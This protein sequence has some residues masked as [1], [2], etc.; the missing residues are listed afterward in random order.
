MAAASI[1]LSAAL[2][3]LGQTP[4]GE[5]TGT[6][7]PDPLAAKQAMIRDGI[8]RLEDRMLRLSK[9]LAD[10]DP[11]SATRLEQ[12]LRRARELLIIRKT[13][14]IIGL[15]EQDRLTDA[16][17]KQ[18]QAIE[19][20]HTILQL[21]LRELGDLKKREEEIRRLEELRDELAAIIKEQQ[22]ERADSRQA[23][24]LE[25]Q[26]AAINR[27][28]A[29]LK[30][31]IAREQDELAKTTRAEAASSTDDGPGLA[32]S[33]QA[34]RTDT[35]AFAERLGK[36]GEMSKAG[37]A[38]KPEPNEA[39]P[40]ASDLQQA[41]EAINQAASEM[42][43]AEQN[44][45]GSKLG[46]AR[47]DQEGAIEDLRRALQRLEKRHSAA[48][49]KLDY[50]KQAA[51]Q[52]G[53]EAKTGKLAERMAGGQGTG[54]QGASQAAQQQSQPAPGTQNVQQAQKRM[55]Q[56]AD[57]LDCKDP[58]EAGDQQDKALDEL[59]QAQRQLED[60]LR[61]LQREQQQETLAALEGRFRAMLAKQLEIN[62]TTV[63]L[64]QTRQDHWRRADELKLSEL[65]KEQHGLGDE[66][67]K[68]VRVL[69]QDATTVVFPRIVD[70]IRQEMYDV[71][72]R[73]ADKKVATVTQTM[74]AEIAAT[75][76]DLIDALKQ[77]R[78]G[79]GGGQGGAGC[80]GKMALLPGSAEL[81]LLR[82]CQ[83]RVKNQTET[84]D[85]QRRQQP[86]PRADLTARMK[87]LSQRQN[88]LARMAKQIHE[89]AA[90]CSK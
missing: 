51:A 84:L 14:E 18:K 63:A 9:A 75:L 65:S 3:G 28:I 83:V 45:S 20:L 37:P 43:S 60:A 64:D 6:T 16:S 72:D 55:Q 70:Q 13:D 36:I 50:D 35:E 30:D 10:T 86:A 40:G 23:D 39:R 41:Q 17:D 15:L 57:G 90:T 73:L 48:R 38:A 29:D 80:A 19:D 81:K 26:L 42:T 66:A 11:A 24:S 34:V 71:S 58:A 21:L 25:E 2:V 85:E 22:A 4:G 7:R 62:K 77:Q 82:S 49:D 1:V 33:Q 76:K 67:A 54:S 69:E 44:L 5:P 12:A 32:K 47:K 59:Q 27:A 89:Q 78:G 68:V 88:E 79:G 31:L 87:D 53:T 56:A 52:R 8:A 74:Q 61:Q 46:A